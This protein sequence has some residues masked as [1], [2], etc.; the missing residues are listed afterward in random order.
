MDE[1]VV[2]GASIEVP[3]EAPDPMV[4][5]DEN[6]LDKKDDGGD[7]LYR[8][9]LLPCPSRLGAGMAQHAPDPQ[10]AHAIGAARLKQRIGQLPGGLHADMSATVAQSDRQ[11]PRDQR[12]PLFKAPIALRVLRRRDFVEN[13][14]KIRF[15]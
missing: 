6:E 7:A 1:L 9:R 8:Q 10:Q 2:K 14:Q 15:H 5:H 11:R 4:G 3:S 13:I 12:R